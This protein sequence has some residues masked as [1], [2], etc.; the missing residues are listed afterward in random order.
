[1]Q[2]GPLCWAPVVEQLMVAP[3]WSEVLFFGELIEI[4]QFQSKRYTQPL[5]QENELFL[6]VLGWGEEP[7]IIANGEFP[8]G[9]VTEKSLFGGS[10]SLCARGP[11]SAPR[12]EAKPTI[13]LFLRGFAALWYPPSCFLRYFET[14]KDNEIIFGLSSVAL[15]DSVG[16]RL[17]AL[18]HCLK[19]VR[20]CIFGCIKL[21]E[22]VFAVDQ[23]WSIL[24]T[25]WR[26]RVRFRCAVSTIG[27]DM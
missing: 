15:L 13:F 7:E 14:P 24:R 16:K 5:L 27:C 23:W 8:W 1:M 19:P 22:F 11:E 12:I 18:I 20:L 9:L 25:G 6:G 10:R 2:P 26:L 4:R 3:R 17:L 21:T